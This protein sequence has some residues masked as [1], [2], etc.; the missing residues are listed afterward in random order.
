MHHFL[1]ENCE[2]DHPLQKFMEHGKAFYTLVCERIAKKK[3]TELAT[4]IAWYYK[5]ISHNWEFTK[6]ENA[7]GIIAPIPS[8]N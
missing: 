3:M 6:L 1:I 5:Q 7:T 8:L 2:E 4:K